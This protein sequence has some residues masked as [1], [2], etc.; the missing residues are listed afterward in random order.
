MLTLVF[1][2]MLL[3]LTSI[4]KLP[5]L[6]I[7]GHGHDSVPRIIGPGAGFFVCGH[8]WKAA[9]RTIPRWGQ[10]PVM[11]PF[12]AEPDSPVSHLPSQLDRSPLILLA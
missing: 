3:N 8:P 2:F 9:S 11:I 6:S 7:G 1:M 10:P 5:T 4:W 12:L